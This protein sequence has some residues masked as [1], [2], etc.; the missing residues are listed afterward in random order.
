[1]DVGEFGDYLL[2]YKVFNWWVKIN[3]CWVLLK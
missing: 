2:V 3:G 1:M